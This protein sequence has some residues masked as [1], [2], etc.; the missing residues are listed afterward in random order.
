MPSPSATLPLLVYAP[1]GTSPHVEAIVLTVNDASSVDSLYVKAHQPFYHRGGNEKG[2]HEGF[3]VAGAASIQI[4]DGPWVD[5]RDDNIGC[6]AQE[7]RHAQCVGG[8][9][10]TIR[11]TIPAGTVRSGTNTIRFQFHGSDGI[12]SGYRVLGVG[13]MR[14]SDPSVQSFDPQQHGAHDPTQLSYDDASTW[15]PPHG[16]EAASDAAAG[17]Q[18]FTSASLLEGPSGR[19]IQASCGS[20]HARDGRDLAYFSYSNRTIA[21]RSRFHGLSNDQ[22]QQ[23]AAYIRSIDLKKRDGST[24]APPGSPWDP[25]YQPGPTLV[26]TGKH[27]DVSDPVYWAAG[28]GLDAVLNREA[29]M[30]PHL[31]P[32]GEGGV[33]YY[34][35]PHGTRALRW[36]HL[37][38]DSTLN[39]RAIPL[40]IQ[41]PDWNNWLPDVHPMDAFPS[42]WDAS[43]TRAVYEEGLQSVLDTYGGKT[44]RDALRTIDKE[45]RRF[46][47]GFTS[48]LKNAAN[49]TDLSENR[50]SLARLSNHQWLATKA[51][52]TFHGHHLEDVADDLVTEVTQFGPTAGFRYRSTERRPPAG[53]VASS[54][55][56]GSTPFAGSGPF[57]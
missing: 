29:D 21:A 3:D 34:T 20:C 6:P 22:A 43:R 10:S 41:F 23:I 2:R 14:P 38:M 50:F 37:H 56:R 27:P 40:S 9:F 36:H 13:F 54:I 51:W 8:V 30:L 24:Y 45:I 49:E 28:A 42:Q 4:N 18:W 57:C 11:F 33:D 48:D 7:R 1:D 46:H 31:F 19:S 17:R 53:A 44:D 47:N 25:P 26:A 55:L 52:E 32:D 35:T 15:G 39:M 12:R 5:V 16:Y